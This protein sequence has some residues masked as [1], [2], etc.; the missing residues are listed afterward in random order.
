MIEF[1]KEYGITT[2]D[3]EY[4]IHNVDKGIIQ[5]IALSENNVREILDFYNDIG[6]TKELSNIIIY[7]PDLIL[8]NK[9]NLKDTISKIDVDVFKTVI[10][11]SIDDLIL[12]GI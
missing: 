8:T 7:R 3:Y 9:E 4:I 1:I 5:N 11:K 10:H 12:L 6:I 2:I